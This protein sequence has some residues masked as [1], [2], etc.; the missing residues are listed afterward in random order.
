MPAEEV[1]APKSPVS[2][3]TAADN[4]EKQPEENEVSDESRVSPAPKKHSEENEKGKSKKIVQHSTTGLLR[5]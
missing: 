2:E 5:R 3:K 4:G 1:V